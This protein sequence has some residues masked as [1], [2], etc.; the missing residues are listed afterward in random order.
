MLECVKV[1][2]DAGIVHTDLKPA[3]FVLVKGALKL[4]DFGIAKAIPNDTTNIARDQQIGTLSYMSPEALCDAGNGP[5][6]ER[7]MKVR[8]RSDDEANVADGSTV[9]RLVPRL[10]ALPGP[11]AAR[12][13]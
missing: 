7:L 8:R 9:R 1:V 4:I 3:N 11:T 12:V 6:G 2:H 13:T 10:L 5:G